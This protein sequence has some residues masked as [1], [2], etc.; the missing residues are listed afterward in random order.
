MATSETAV[1]YIIRRNEVSKRKYTGGGLSVWTNGHGGGRKGRHRCHRQTFRRC[2]IGSSPS[3]S[4]ALFNR[5]RGIHAS[6][7]RRRASDR[8][9]QYATGGA[10]FAY[11]SFSAI[12]GFKKRSLIRYSLSR[13]QRPSNDPP[14]VAILPAGAA[15][16]YGTRYRRPSRG[17]YHPECGLLFPNG[18]TQRPAVIPGL[19]SRG[20]TRVWWRSVRLGHAGVWPRCQRRHT[21]VIMTSESKG[22]NSSYREFLRSQVHLK[23]VYIKY[24]L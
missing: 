8:L 3:S 13:Y 9:R 4:L 5:R 1:K 6:A 7:H 16:N 17:Q 11:K 18:Q 23:L 15:T 22:F 2:T 19:T 24:P 12:T 21:Q 10:V 20:A 14:L